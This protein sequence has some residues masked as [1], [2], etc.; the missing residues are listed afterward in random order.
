MILTQ[1]MHVHQMFMIVTVY[2]MDLV[3]QQ[4]HLVIAVIQVKLIVLESVT[5]QYMVLVLMD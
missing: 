5:L 4:Q 2:V 3:V 1:T